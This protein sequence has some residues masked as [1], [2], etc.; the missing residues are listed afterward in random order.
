MTPPTVTTPP[1]WILPDPLLDPSWYGETWIKY[2]LDRKL[3]PSRFGHVFE[4]RSLFRV[5]MNDFC[6]AA[7]TE[8]PGVT[9]EKAEELYANLQLWYENLA[10]PLL[11]RTIVLPG[12]MQLQ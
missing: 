7:H 3:C 5:V 12:H 2:P 1:T 8:G 4:S 10:Q 9:L 11:A 6:R